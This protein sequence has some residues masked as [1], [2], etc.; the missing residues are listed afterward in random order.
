MMYQNTN[1]DYLH[2]LAEGMDF[3][4]DQCSVSFSSNRYLE[5]NAKGIDK[6]RGL[7]ELCDLLNIDIKDTMAIG[8]N[9]N[10]LSMIQEAGIG[11]CVANGQDILKEHSDYICENDHNHSAVAEAIYRFMGGNHYEC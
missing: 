11:V 7:K 10:D 6:G 5:F 2:E 1:M 3:V 8:D 4:H 9:Y